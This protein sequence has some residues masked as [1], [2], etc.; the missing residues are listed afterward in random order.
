MR[1]TAIN[2]LVCASWPAKG[3]SAWRV[4][5]VHDASFAISLACFGVACVI[6]AVRA[7]IQCTDVTLASGLDGYVHTPNYLVVPGVNE[8]F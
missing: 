3:A 6:S 4:H 7:E 1:R 2:R 8:W 5:V